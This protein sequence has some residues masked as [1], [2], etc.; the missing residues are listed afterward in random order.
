MGFLKAIQ[1]IYMSGNSN[2]TEALAERIKDSWLISFLF[3]QANGSG[4]FHARVTGSPSLE[5]ATDIYNL[6]ISPQ[7]FGNSNVVHIQLVEKVGYDATIVVSD[8]QPFIMMIMEYKNLVGLVGKFQ[9]TIHDLMYPVIP[10]NPDGTMSIP[11]FLHLVKQKIGQFQQDRNWLMADVYQNQARIDCAFDG[12]IG[13][14]F[15]VA[16]YE[17]FRIPAEGKDFLCF[18]NFDGHQTILTLCFKYQGVVHTPHQ[19]ALAG[20]TVIAQ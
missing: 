11:Q 5:E 3:N 13:C 2:D 14:D 1:N 17:H 6:L 16:L 8:V 7:Y 12:E 20:Y 15:V 9:A 4:P 18:H 19:Q 10:P